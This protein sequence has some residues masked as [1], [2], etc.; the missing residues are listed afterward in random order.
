MCINS[1]FLKDF[2][3]AA[4]VAPLWKEREIVKPHLSLQLIGCY[5][6]TLNS[7][8][9]FLAV[10]LHVITCYLQKVTKQLNMKVKGNMKAAEYYSPAF[11]SPAILICIQFCSSF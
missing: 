2:C 11:S 7:S 10:H 1:S 6:V 9:G 5:N 3:G 4:S 8:V